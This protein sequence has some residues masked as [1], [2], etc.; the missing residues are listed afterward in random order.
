MSVALG[1]ESFFIALGITCLLGTFACVIECNHMNYSPERNIGY[2]DTPS[3]DSVIDLSGVYIQSERIPD[4]LNPL[5]NDR[6]ID[7]SQNSDSLV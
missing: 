2:A 6:F 1:M 3:L 5:F 4:T 7:I